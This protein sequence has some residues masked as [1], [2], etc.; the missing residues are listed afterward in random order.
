MIYDDLL[1]ETIDDSEVFNIIEQLIKSGQTEYIT[2]KSIYDKNEMQLY[3]IKLNNTKLPE[4]DSN[5][6]RFDHHS[7]VFKNEELNLNIEKN[8]N[9]ELSMNDIDLIDMENITT[10]VIVKT[11][12]EIKNIFI[13]GFKWL[14]SNLWNQNIVHGDLTKNN[15][16]YDSFFDHLFFIDWETAMRLN[17]SEKPYY[18]NMRILIDVVDYIND[19][20]IDDDSEFESKYNWDAT[21][22]CNNRNVKKCEIW[23]GGYK[24]FK[25]FSDN[26]FLGFHSMIKYIE[27][28]ELRENEGYNKIYFNK[29]KIQIQNWLTIFNKFF[30]ININLP[31]PPPPPSS[32]LLPP[33][34]PPS[35]RSRSTSQNP[36]PKRSRFTSQN[37][38]PK[39]GGSTSSRKPKPNKSRKKNKVYKGFHL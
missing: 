6:E 3:Y 22:T 32:Q 30:G 10:R 20:L 7:F 14:C 24:K 8:K 31:P 23:K 28:C 19:F 38:Q 21:I 37:S 35:K 13:G 11:T 25:I 39:R 33:P 16:I 29:N 17:K 18:S 15:L 1:I 5:D 2:Y 26:D 34:P 9:E 27:L 12:A 36:Q 4:Y